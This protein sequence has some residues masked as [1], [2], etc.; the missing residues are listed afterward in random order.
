[1]LGYYVT[2]FYSSLQNATE[3][4]TEYFADD[5]RIEENFE[6][7][8]D[9]EIMEVYKP[10]DEILAVIEPEEY[11]SN[12]GDT[13]SIPRKIT[14]FIKELLGAKEQKLYKAGLI[15]QDDLTTRG[16]NALWTILYKEHKDE[17]V[18]KAEEI[19]KEAE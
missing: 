15:D 6:E 5:R 2:D 12:K 19:L 1:M 8:P 7:D 16:K 13:M 4:E 18:E 14:D 11:Q 10:E 3:A 9:V 17:L